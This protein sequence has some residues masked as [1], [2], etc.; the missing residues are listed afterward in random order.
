MKKIHLIVKC[1]FGSGMVMEWQ[2]GYAEIKPHS[3]PL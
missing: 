1:S 3:V 2:E